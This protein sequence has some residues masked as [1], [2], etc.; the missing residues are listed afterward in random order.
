MRDLLSRQ[1]APTYLFLHYLPDNRSRILG[2]DGTP[3]KA[4]LDNEEQKAMSAEVCVDLI[5]KAMS[6]RK[7]ELVMT[8][9]GKLGLWLKLLAPNLIDSIAANAVSSQNAKS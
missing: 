3:V 4:T 1:T 2:A 9:K 8:L 6:D 7:R 5:L